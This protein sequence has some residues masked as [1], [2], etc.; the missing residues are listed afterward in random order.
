MQ[1]GDHQICDFYPKL[2]IYFFTHFLPY[3][4]T[5]FVSEILRIVL[6]KP[7]RIFEKVGMTFPRQLFLLIL[8]YFGSSTKCLSRLNGGNESLK[9]TNLHCHY[10]KFT[11][12]SKFRWL[13]WNAVWKLFYYKF[14]PRMKMQLPKI[15]MRPKFE[16]KLFIYRIMQFC[17]KNKYV[18]ITYLDLHTHICIYVSC[19][20]LK[21]H[22][23][24]WNQVQ[25]EIVL[26]RYR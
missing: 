1:H 6:S 11:S 25:Q 26:C 4:V 7:T 5:I 15:S 24:A 10:K 9:M 3:S 19:L 16:I 22:A 20:P 23:P 17:W 8:C 2:C 18:T 12:E 13:R 14:H 21:N